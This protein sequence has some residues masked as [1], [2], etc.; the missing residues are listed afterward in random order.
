[1]GEYHSEKEKMR[2][3]AKS[4]L[5]HAR[6]LVNPNSNINRHCLVMAPDA[7]F[8]VIWDIVCMFMIIYEMIMIPFRLSFEDLELSM[9]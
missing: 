1:M 8:R 6:S 7:N 4:D 2:E 9:F 3:N 5:K